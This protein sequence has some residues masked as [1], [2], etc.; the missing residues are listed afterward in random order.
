[1]THDT[2]QKMLPETALYYTNSSFYL[3][4]LWQ[5]QFSVYIFIVLYQLHVIM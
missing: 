3:V 2:T 5:L 4:L 1:M